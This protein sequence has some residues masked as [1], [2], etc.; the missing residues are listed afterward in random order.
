MP[1]MRTVGTAVVRVLAKMYHDKYNIME[2][3]IERLK[4]E[5]RVREL[6][7]AVTMLSASLR[8]TSKLLVKATPR[9]ARPPIPMERR[10]QV[11]ASQNWKCQSPYNDCILYIVGDGTFQPNMLFEVDHIE[12]WSQCFR[13]DRDALQALCVTCHAEKT[14]RE[15]L[16]LLDEQQQ[17]TEPE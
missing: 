8:E 15:R 1:S 7:D 9:P 13:N 12:P 10:L 14:R 6:E 4:L 17:A 11:A 5:K 2:A 3:E 16:K